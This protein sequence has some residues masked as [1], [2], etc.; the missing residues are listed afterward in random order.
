MMTGKYIINNK[1][2]KQF[3]QQKPYM[4]VCINNSHWNIERLQVCI[5]TFWK[6]L[7]FRIQFQNINNSKFQHFKIISKFLAS[8]RITKI[9]KILQNPYADKDTDKTIGDLS[10][11][12]IP[13]WKLIISNIHW[14]IKQY[15]GKLTPS[16][17]QFQSMYLILFSFWSHC[18]VY[19]TW[20]FN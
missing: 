2:W 10:L 13:N 1:N 19:Y 6:R 5:K 15:M 3:W 11:E 17:V 7:K 20:K 9:T 4:S 8:V 14:V 12:H 18:K 16:M